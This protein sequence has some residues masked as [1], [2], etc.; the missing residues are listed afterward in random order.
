MN[1]GPDVLRRVIVDHTFDSADI[2]ASGS[3]VC[4]DQPAWRTDQVNAAE[5]SYKAAAQTKQ[6]QRN[7]DVRFRKSRRRFSF[8]VWILVM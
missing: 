3:C 2:D 7:G 8:A 5:Q 4:A 1:V 6:Y